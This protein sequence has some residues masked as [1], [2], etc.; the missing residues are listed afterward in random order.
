MLWKKYMDIKNLYRCLL[1]RFVRSVLVINGEF[2]QAFHHSAIIYWFID[3]TEEETE[4][5]QMSFNILSNRVDFTK[6]YYIFNRTIPGF[7]TFSAVKYR[8][9]FIV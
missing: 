8:V 9:L 3:A 5:C 4:G 7:I 2:S 6:I 1:Y